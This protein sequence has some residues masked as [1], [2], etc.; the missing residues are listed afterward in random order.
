MDACP[1]VPRAGKHPRSSP[2]CTDAGS[3][4]HLQPSLPA[5]LLE[6]S[7]AANHCLPALPPLGLCTCRLAC[8]PPPLDPSRPPEIEPLLGN[9]LC[10]RRDPLLIFGTA[11]T[12]LNP[13]SRVC[14]KDPRTKYLMTR[15]QLALGLGERCCAGGVLAAFSFWARASRVAGEHRVG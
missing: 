14:G 12:S 13:K 3:L 7:A 10:V 1:L 5:F 8:W 11:T 2:T 4:P 9:S 6:P 15:P